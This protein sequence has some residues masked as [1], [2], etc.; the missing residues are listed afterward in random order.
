[1]F[2]IVVA[3]LIVCVWLLLIWYY[4]GGKPREPTRSKNIVKEDISSFSDATETAN[5]GNT[6]IMQDPDSEKENTPDELKE[7]LN[8]V[9]TSQPFSVP[10]DVLN[11]PE[12]A[13]SQHNWVCIAKNNPLR[14]FPRRFTFK[15]TK[16]PHFPADFYVSLRLNEREKGKMKKNKIIISNQESFSFDVRNAEDATITCKLK[17]TSHLGLK[18]S[19]V[20]KRKVNLLSM[21]LGREVEL[22]SDVRIAITNIDEIMDELPQKGKHEATTKNQKNASESVQGKIQNAFRKAYAKWNLIATMWNF[23][24]E[25]MMQ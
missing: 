24:L 3:F 5:D 18:K 20:K 23:E 8:S 14:H 1:M 21:G 4:G 2:T 13:T 11:V 6:I 10:L 22:L 15:M 17:R 16:I 7:N 19:T 12:R 9:P 25:M